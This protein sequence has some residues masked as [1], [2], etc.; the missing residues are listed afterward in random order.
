MGK[1]YKDSDYDD[2]LSRKE[3]QRQR[4][5]ARKTRDHDRMTVLDEKLIPDKDS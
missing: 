2:A 3:K 1:T 5:E 4:Q